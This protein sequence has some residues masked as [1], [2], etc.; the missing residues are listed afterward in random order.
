MKIMTVLFETLK[1][2]SSYFNLPFFIC[3]FGPTMYP[4]S[5]PNFTLSSSATR[6]ARLMT[7]TFLGWVQIIYFPFN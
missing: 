4:T 6:L 5:S 7:A 2:S 3:N 1:F